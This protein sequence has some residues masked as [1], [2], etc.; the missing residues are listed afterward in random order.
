MVV[1]AVDVVEDALNDLRNA[2]GKRTTM[3][4]VGSLRR[5]TWYEVTATREWWSTPLMPTRSE[6][7][8]IEVSQEVVLCFRGDVFL[9]SKDGADK[10]MARGKSPNIS[11]MNGTEAGVYVPGN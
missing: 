4:N 2:W 5:P 8:G 3:E 10:G 9:G 1:A 7:I 6:V 11:R